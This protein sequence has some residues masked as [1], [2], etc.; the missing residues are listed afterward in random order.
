MVRTRI[1][2]AGLI[3]L[4]GAAAAGSAAQATTGRD[5]A[6]GRQV[7]GYFIQWGI[8]GRNYKVKNVET[9][10]MRRS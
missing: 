2:L 1:A 5:T 10:A 6:R 4:L 9:A 8:Y 7:V 3:V